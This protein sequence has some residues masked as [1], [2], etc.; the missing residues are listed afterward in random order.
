MRIDQLNNLEHD[1]NFLLVHGF[2]EKT[3]DLMNI[4][5]R[6]DT[7]ELIKFAKKV[8]EIFSKDMPDGSGDIYCGF[9]TCY[10]TLKKEIYG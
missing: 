6:E 8:H 7:L 3:Q 9:K 5:I 2:N 1:I 10:E 4:A